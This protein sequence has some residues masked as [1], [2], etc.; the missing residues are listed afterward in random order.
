MEDERGVMPQPGTP[1]ALSVPFSE[2]DLL[3]ISA[4]Q[5]VVFCERQF[6]LI[7]V[8]RAW[9]ENVLT[10]EGRA[11]HEKVDEGVGEA[12]G[13]LRIGRSVPLQSLRL[14]IV[15]VADV[16][17]LRR[18]ETAGVAVACLAGRWAPKPVEYKRGRPKEHRADEVQLCAQALCL[19]EMLGAAI[20]AGALF[21]GKTRHRL[22]VAFNSELRELVERAARRA[23]E[24]L[25]AG[26]TPVARREPKCDSC[27]LLDLC[28]PEALS[29][30]ARRYLGGAF[31]ELG[32]ERP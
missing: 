32:G 10:A 19:E 6:A 3:P 26:L 12:R 14:G 27:S 4:L 22:E 1:G 23:R 17:E 16:V 2:D 15:G 20:P 8:E 13:E 18:D 25:D 7:H 30:S 5:H 29:R 21:Y 31:S 11:L 9:T 28:R 24:I